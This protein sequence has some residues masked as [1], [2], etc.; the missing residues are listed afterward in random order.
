MDE[1]NWNQEDRL[2]QCYYLH[3]LAY[4]LLGDCTS[5]KP[6]FDATAQLDMSPRGREITLD[7]IG[8]CA[9]ADPNF[10]PNSIATSPPPTNEPPPPIGIY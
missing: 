8:L 2:E 1:Q 9:D 6:L 4:Y 10:D 7:G 5:A 3:G